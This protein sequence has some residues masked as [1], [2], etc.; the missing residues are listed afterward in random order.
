MRNRA[1]LL[2]TVL[3]VLALAPRPAAARPC[4]CSDKA[5]IEKALAMVEKTRAA[6]STVLAD[7]LGDAK[8]APKTMAAAKDAFSAN[9]NWKK[10]EVRKVGGLD[11]NTGETIIDEDFKEEH[12]DGV[13][14]G[15]AV[16]ERAHFWFFVS[17]T[18]V[19]FAASP[20]LL[21]KMLVRSEIDARDKEERYLK[22]QLAEVRK[23]CGGWLCRCTREV[24]PSAPA[25][26][27]GC[28]AASLKCAAPTCLKL[29]PD[30]GNPADTGI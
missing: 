10:G 1:R 27:S 5:D 3:L 6:W 7:I 8:D 25:C 15:V 26:G 11:P 28:P 14:E 20:S 9:M 24:F 4:E 13:V 18:V 16:H 23:L 29:D 19:V 17:Q 12:C 2:V 21:A 22:Q 30:P